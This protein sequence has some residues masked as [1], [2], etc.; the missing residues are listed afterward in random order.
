MSGSAFEVF[1]LSAA[2]FMVEDD[3]SQF[4]DDLSM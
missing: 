2:I 1:A 4:W 3:V